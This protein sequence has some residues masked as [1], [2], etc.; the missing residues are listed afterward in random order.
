[1]FCTQSESNTAESWNR[2]RSNSKNNRL[3]TVS[4][5]HPSPFDVNEKIEMRKKIHHKQGNGS[6]SEL[7]IPRINLGIRSIGETLRNDFRSTAHHRS[8]I[9]HQELNTI[10]GSRLQSGKNRYQSFEVY[11]KISVRQDI[12]KEKERGATNFSRKGSWYGIGNRAGP[13]DMI[14]HLPDY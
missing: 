10:D 7:K 13:L 4:M 9:G 6:W 12:S 14:F 1:M 3:Q 8:S 2:P 11:Q 5:Y